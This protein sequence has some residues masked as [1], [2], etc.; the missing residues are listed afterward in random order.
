[1]P[2]LS[3]FLPRRSLSHFIDPLGIDQIEEMPGGACVT[4]SAVVAFQIN[5]VKL[6]EIA[7]SVG[8]MA[9]IFSAHASARA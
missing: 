5:L 2:R 7:K 1:M 4:Q 9:R 3:R 6:T 8:F